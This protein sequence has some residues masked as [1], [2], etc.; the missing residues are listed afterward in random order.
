MGVFRITFNID[1][2]LSLNGAQ[3]QRLAGAIPHPPSVHLASTHHQSGLGKTEGGM[4]REEKQVMEENEE[5]EKE[6]REK[7]D[8]GTEEGFEI[9][10]K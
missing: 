9:D 7:K 10:E 2:F 5:D 1:H 6:R 3:C 4:E 8:K